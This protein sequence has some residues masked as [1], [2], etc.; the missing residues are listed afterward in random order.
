M[1]NPPAKDFEKGA[2]SVAGAD[3]EGPFAVVE[4]D[5]GYYMGAMPV[6]PKQG[7]KGK[8]LQLFSFARPHMLSFHFSWA[9][10][11]SAFVC[12]FAFAPLMPIVKASLGMSLKQVFAVNIAS[13][14]ST[15]SARFVVGPLVDRVGPRKCQTFLLVW[16]AIMT[17]LGASVTTIWGLG[18][19]RFMIGFAGATFV[20]TQSWTTGLFVSEIVGTANAT[21]GGW[22]NLGG[23]VTYQL[24]LGTYVGFLRILPVDDAWRASFVVP[25]SITLFIAISMFCMADDGPRGDLQKLQASGVVEK[26]AISQSMRK[27]FLNYNSWILGVQYGCCFGVELHMT[28]IGGVYFS[29]RKSFDLGVVDGGLCASLFGYMNLF[30]GR[31]EAR[32]PTS[33]QNTKAMRGRMIAQWFMLMGVGVMLVIFGTRVSIHAAI[34]SLIVFSAFVQSAEGSTFGIVPFVDPEYVGGVSAVVGAWGNIGAMFW[35]LLFL[36]VYAEDGMEGL[37]LGFQ[38]MGYIIMCAAQTVF[39][40][41]IDGHSHMTGTCEKV[42]D[43]V[44]EVEDI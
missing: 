25:A 38:M 44:K 32:L 8:E 39:L 10:F 34:A 12:W 5:G 22:D 15:V 18:L 16:A 3:T 19:V 24:M 26:K 30:A 42:V 33:S 31:A 27:G 4:R 13:V 17:L 11:F 28:N 2:V 37:A 40:L 29:N 9:S 20:V 1:C 14:A 23:S 43:S 35:G 21:A 7:F 41:R 36:N 6:D